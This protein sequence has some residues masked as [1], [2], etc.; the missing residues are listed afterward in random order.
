MRRTPAKKE[1]TRVAVIGAGPTGLFFAGALKSAMKGMVDITIFEKRSVNTR[2][3]A[4]V[5]QPNVMN[6]LNYYK[7]K[8]PLFSKRNSDGCYIRPPFRDQAAV[9]IHNQDAASRQRLQMQGHGVV[10][11]A[12]LQDELR[13]WN[14]KLRNRLDIYDVKLQDL[15]QMASSGYFQYIIGADGS[16]GVTTNSWLHLHSHHSQAISHGLT[17]VFREPSPVTRSPALPLGDLEQYRYRGFR[18][19]K[20][21]EVYLGVQLLDEEFA[22]I[23]GPTKDY[24]QLPA[25]LQQAVQSAS[26]FYGIHL[27]KDGRKIDVTVFPI[28]LPDVQQFTLQVH[29]AQVLIMGDAAAQAHFFTGSG[30]VYGME[31]GYFASQMIARG[32]FDPQAYQQFM[33][34]V[35][36]RTVRNAKHAVLSHIAFDRC[37]QRPFQSNAFDFTG[38][39]KKEDCLLINKST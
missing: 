31:E 33:T 1:K 24:D 9:C 38:L 30:V 36:N 22:Q 10:S 35:S 11:I 7:L 13:E 19:A 12:D 21:H 28:T 39:D 18:F 5:I 34:K 14:K 25:G 4:I 3:Q 8:V 29:R 15:E 27:P 37:M 32:E 20:R 17:A 2:T 16:S 26:T 23:T 6:L